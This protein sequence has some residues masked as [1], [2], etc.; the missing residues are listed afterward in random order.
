MRRAL[1]GHG[2][3]RQGRRGSVRCG[4]AWYGSAAVR[5]GMSGKRERDKACLG[6]STHGAARRGQAGMAWRALAG[7]VTAGLVQVWLVEAGLVR[8]CLSRRGEAGQGLPRQARHD[9]V[10]QGE[11]WCGRAR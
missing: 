1:A 10:R 4:L 11:A 3:V 2:A 7:R 5:Q 8:L 6:G 9:L